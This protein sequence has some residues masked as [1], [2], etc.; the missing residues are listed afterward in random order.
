MPFLEAWTEIFAPH[1]LGL[2]AMRQRAEMTGGRFLIDSEPDRTRWSSEYRRRTHRDPPHLAGWRIRVE[3][4][5]CGQHCPNRVSETCG[6]GTT[7]I[8]VGEAAPPPSPRDGRSER[9]V[10]D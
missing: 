2:V 8:E 6:A 9:H 4:S 1:T 3:Q 10:S 7:V 5:C